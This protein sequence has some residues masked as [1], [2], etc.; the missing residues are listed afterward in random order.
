M[1]ACGVF[2][3]IAVGANRRDPL[4]E[5]D[6]RE[7]GTG[8]FAFYGESA[9]GI[10]ND[11]NS[12]T[13]RRAMGLEEK[14]AAGAEFVQMRVR[15]GDDASC[16][17][18]NRAQQPRL[19]GVDADALHKRG[20]FGFT[21]VFKGARKER[22]WDLLNRQSEGDVVAA[23]G[24][25]AT[26]IWAL[27]KKVGD[28]LLYT[29]E[30]G[31]PFRIRLVGIIQG[32]IL[33]GSLV[34]SENQFR[35]LFPSEDGY[36]VFLVD[37]P[38]AV[39]VKLEGTLSNALSDYGLEVTTAVERL[40]AFNAVEH[41]Y[42]SIFA[43]LG[44]L[45]LV[46]GTVGLGLVVLRNMLERRGEFAMLRAVGFDRRMV[47]RLVIYEHWGLMFYGLACGVAAAVVAVGPALKS[48]GAA[49]PCLS[50]ALITGAI[51]LSGLIW[52]WAA[53]SAAVSGNMLDALRN[54]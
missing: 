13:G 2:L 27:G 31:R 21:E 5:A 52:I 15:D 28:E 6:K 51:A 4:A 48:P 8:G 20:A 38:A 32:S 40:G 29:D 17:N 9:I 36:R 45:G 7:S 30:K 18:L 10:S 37:C 50:L 53:T 3:I 1:L 11:L 35:R 42:L 19:L 44:G 12:Q 26:V 24:D 41:T 43:L 39:R 22:G 23:V 14:D 33:Q 16:F 47:K 46:L 54:E 49:I 25:Y 34:I